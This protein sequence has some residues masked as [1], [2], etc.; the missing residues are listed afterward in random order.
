[1][2]STQRAA[3]ERGSIERV[4]SQLELL[5]RTDETHGV[6]PD[7]RAGANYRK[8]NG[9]WNTRADLPLTRVHRDIRKLA[10]AGGCD[11]LSERDRSPRRRV[12]LLPVM[13]LD[14][15]R[16]VLGAERS[17]DALYEVDEDVDT[18]AHVSTV[19]KRDVVGCLVHSAL[20]RLSQPGRA[21][22]ER[23]SGSIAST[24]VGLERFWQRKVD[25]DLRAVERLSAVVGH[26]HAEEA[27][28]R[29]LTG[30]TAK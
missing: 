20:V 3:R 22:D 19:D 7:D 13:R 21:D 23:S 28:P 6:V 10:P 12:D 8:P 11:G 29:N 27:N 30:I 24:H 14:D 5:L 26:G 18:D 2:R 17:R 16:V 9:A 15:L 1:L 25:R 4:M